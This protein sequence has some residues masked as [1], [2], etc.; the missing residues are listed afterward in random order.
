MNHPT[1]FQEVLYELSA[2]DMFDVSLSPE[3][4]DAIYDRIVKDSR[5]SVWPKTFLDW[6]DAAYDAMEELG[7]QLK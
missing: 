3:E 7:Y 6:R 4:E 5:R 2:P 1:I